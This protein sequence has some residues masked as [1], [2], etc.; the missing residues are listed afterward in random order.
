[1]KKIYRQG[2]VLL[3]QSTVQ[4]AVSAVPVPNDG[5]GRVILA[6]G[7]V[8]GHAHA[9]HEVDHVRRFESSGMSF[10][11]VLDSV[12]LRHEEHTHMTIP[13]GVYQLLIQNEYTPE[14][15]RNVQD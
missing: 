13:A 11:Q 7:E 12:T 10:L 14:E 15:L 4:P 6:H 5:S 9:I 3:V 8:T 1:M 2:D